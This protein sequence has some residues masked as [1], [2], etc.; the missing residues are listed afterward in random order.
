MLVD[1][2]LRS[3]GFSEELLLVALEVLVRVLLASFTWLCFRPSP[4]SCTAAEPPLP[5]RAAMVYHELDVTNMP[6]IIAGLVLIDGCNLGRF[7]LFV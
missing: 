7:H 5:R 6:F 2:S 3:C 1:T 4:F